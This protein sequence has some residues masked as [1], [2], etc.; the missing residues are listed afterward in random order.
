MIIPKPT[1]DQLDRVLNSIWT[2]DASLPLRK[3][4]EVGSKFLAIWD[5]LL[6][7]LDSKGADIQTSG[8]WEMMKWEFHQDFLSVFESRDS[9]SIEKFFELVK[10]NK[11]THGIGYGEEMFKV[12][13][14]EDTR[15]SF[16]EDLW[17]QMIVLGMSVGA[18][19]YWSFEQ[20][21]KFNPYEIPLIEL[22]EK[23]EAGIGFKISANGDMGNF[24]LR[25]GDSLIDER[26]C[27]DIFTA[28]TVS[29]ILSRKRFSKG[30]V[31]EIGAGMGGVA[32]ILYKNFNIRVD[33]YDLPIMNILQI[34]NLSTS[35][36]H[37]ILD[38]PRN[39]NMINVLPYFEFA[40]Q[41]YELVLNRDSFPEMQREQLSKY[42]IRS[43]KVSNNLLSIN[44]ESQNLDGTIDGRQHWAHKEFVKSGLWKSCLRLPYPFRDGYVYELM[45]IKR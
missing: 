23:V 21:N 44:Q 35:V 39:N 32:E 29:Q 1:P 41:K 26:I 12:F 43:A 31:A 45:T 19:P 40:K 13:S 4:P 42:I 33:I 18:I 30:K 28:W 2:S 22:K 24:G 25:I 37:K 16:I 17:I 36:S 27:Q 3:E 15:K 14:S 9:G 20:P 7:Q 5:E 8:V 34:A 11:V 10:Q 6:K 38:D